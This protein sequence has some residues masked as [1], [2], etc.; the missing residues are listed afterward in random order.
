MKRWIAIAVL[1]AIVIGLA[2]WNI[3]GAVTAP[4]NPS[5]QSLMTFVLTDHSEAQPNEQGYISHAVYAKRFLDNARKAGI[6]GYTVLATIK[7][8]VLVFAG[9]EVKSDA[10]IYIF[11]ADDK[12]VKLEKGKSFRLLNPEMAGT[13]GEGDDTILDILI[14]GK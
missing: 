10:W 7:G 2:A 3:A 14:M 11:A 6:A 1:A 8:R 4:K 9:F 13:F 12:E 5:Y